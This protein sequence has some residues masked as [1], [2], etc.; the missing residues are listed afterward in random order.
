M[1]LLPCA[2]PAIALGQSRYFFPDDILYQR[3]I[4][5]A[6]MMDEN[7]SPARRLAKRDAG[8][9][10]SEATLSGGRFSSTEGRIALAFGRRCDR[11]VVPVPGHQSRLAKSQINAGHMSQ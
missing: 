3:L 2:T 7:R 10:A 6:H 8:H 9:R 5:L 1:P 11:L 4:L